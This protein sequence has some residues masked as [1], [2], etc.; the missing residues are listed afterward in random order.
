MR[1]RITA[2]E[3]FFQN[4]KALLVI[5][6]RWLKLGWNPLRLHR[7]NKDAL[8]LEVAVHFVR[9]VL[10]SQHEQIADQAAKRNRHWCKFKFSVAHD[11]S[12]PLEEPWRL[13]TGGVAQ[14]RF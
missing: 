13:L 3:S 5:R 4:L 14:Q 1:L 7:L 6:Q 9:M 11:L 8:K 10:V 2:P 12:L